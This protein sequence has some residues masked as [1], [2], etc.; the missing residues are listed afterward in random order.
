MKH[1][2][3]IAFIAKTL[4]LI[5]VASSLTACSLFSRSEDSGKGLVI[6]RDV[7]KLEEGAYYTFDGEKYQRL[8]IG[9][10]TFV[11]TS[12]GNDKGNQ[13]N[14]FWLKDDIDYIP[15]MHK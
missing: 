10:R 1:K 7:N 3:K 14:V 6:E 4:L 15:I 11:T 9:D 5:G 8:Y 13:N 12:G 2:K